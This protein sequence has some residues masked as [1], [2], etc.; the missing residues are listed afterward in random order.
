MAKNILIIFFLSLF[1]HVCSQKYNIQHYNT[2][3]GL[4]QNSVKDIIKDKYGFIWL[5]TE[6]GIVRYD[7]AN[8]LVYKNF[9]LNSQRFTYFYGSPEKDSILTTGEYGNIIVLHD[10]KPE[11]SKSN[12]SLYK[13]IIFKDQADY[14]LY[15]SNY[16]YSAGVD[17]N[18]YIRIKK[19]IY[20]ITDDSIVYKPSDKDPGTSLRIN[21]IYKNGPSFFVL[22]GSLFY[23]NHQS[24]KIQQIEKG[25]I[26]NT[27]HGPLFTDPKSK[28]IWSQ[29][30]NQVFIVNNNII[31]TCFFHDKKFRIVKLI[32]MQDDINQDNLISVY[33]DKFYQN[34]YLGSGTEG[35]HI[36]SFPSFTAS[37]NHLKPSSNFYATLPYDDSSV[38]SYSG[39]V[40][41]RY[42][43]VQDYGFKNI[44]SFFMSYDPDKNI[45]VRNEGDVRIYKKEN[46]YSKFTSVPKKDFFLK[47]FFFDENNYYTLAVKQKKDG[48]LEFYGILSIFSK[49]SFTSL[50]KQII[51]RDEVTKFIRQDQN[52]ILVGT[53][54]GLYRVSLNTNTIYTLTP[55]EK[56]SIR[57][58]IKSK[59]GYFWITTL[60]KG[61]YLLK[62]NRLIKMPRDSNG[63]ISSSHTVMEDAKGYLWI[64]TNNGLYK[65][66][67]SQ[68][69]KYAA[70]K[71]T[72]V[73]Y[74]RYSKDSGFITNE[75]NGGSNVSGNM[76]KNGE[77]VL[78]SLNGLVFFDPLKIKSYYPQNMYIERAVVD[79]K[80]VYFK[81]NLYV[82]QESDRMDIFIDVPYYANQ[83]NILIE[84]KLDGHSKKS[85]QPIGKE[86][87]FSIS[88]LSY[89]NHT[90]IVRMLVSDTGKF[91]YKKINIIIPPY[92]YQTV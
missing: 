23:I 87:K 19:G 54:R 50:K 53:M 77:F 63:N 45:M 86:R 52:N 3:N 8:F 34:L 58:I 4:P 82:S 56:V 51:F 68:L 15:Q 14:L 71:K 21:S 38:I 33:Y 7:G 1:Y 42:G 27:F 61:F 35:L 70:D 76:L 22:D 57:N 73:N 69:L 20:Y 25:K 91:V 43:L 36:I 55:N 92:F 40:Y 80:E 75:F 13:N 17:V 65:V 37:K 85:W 24:R 48:T 83:D 78:P 9:P 32:Q 74:Y 59:K 60:G 26:I 28:M 29:I 2:D 66:P 41:N 62:D 5:T 6:N 44:S 49:G 12:K 18:Y 46:N 30:N 64:P 16:S 39:D 88:N 31:Y 89:G 47:D 10:K 72:R 67:E 79:G 81:D 90:L 11:I 84:A